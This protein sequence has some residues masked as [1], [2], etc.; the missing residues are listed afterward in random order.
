MTSTS[1]ETS[2][3]GRRFQGKEKGEQT[4]NDIDSAA[5]F[6]SSTGPCQGFGDLYLV[7]VATAGLG[8]CRSLRAQFEQCAKTQHKASKKVLQELGSQLC[9]HITDSDNDHD[10]DKD[11]E[12]VLCA[13]NLMNQQLMQSYSNAMA[14]N[15]T[16]P[17]KSSGLDPSA[18]V[19]PSV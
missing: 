18:A 7:C 3:D 13:A 4:Q 6:I 11:R 2:T 17:L 8:M 5:A 14:S 1:K 9:P 12:R 15:M 19:N 16:T 10:H